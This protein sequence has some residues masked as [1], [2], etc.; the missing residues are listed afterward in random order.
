MVY[1]HSGIAY[2][3][4]TL[5]NGTAIEQAIVVQHGAPLVAISWRLTDPHPRTPARLFVKP[6]FSGRDYHSLHHEN[7][8]FGFE[9]ER[10]AN[11]LIW[12]P[13]PGIPAIHVLAN[14]EYRH[15]PD[16]YRNFRYDA[17][18]A[19]GLDA[20]EDLAAPGVFS[21]SLTGD[22]ACIIFAAAPDAEVALPAEQAAHVELE[23]RRNVERAPVLGQ[24]VHAHVGQ[25]GMRCEIGRIQRADRGPAKHVEG[26]LLGRENLHQPEQDPSFVGTPRTAA[27]QHD[28]CAR[29][30]IAHAPS[31]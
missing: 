1:S 28:S 29:P 13:Y 30:R 17:E 18:L 3:T 8:A 24:A 5:D 11:R 12:H 26:V 7:G 19:R 20:I 15:R 31:V 27:R 4:F 22:D 21:W 10:R 23:V 25:V 14:G 9:P 2:E 16:W 6:F